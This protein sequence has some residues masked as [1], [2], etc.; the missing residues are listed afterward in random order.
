MFFKYRR[1]LVSVGILLALLIISAFYFNN[2]KPLPER[3]AQS[4]QSLLVT[5]E[6]ASEDDLPIKLR[7]YG[8]LITK[9]SVQL[10]AQAEG[11]IQTVNISDGE[12]VEAEQLLFELENTSQEARL[13]QARANLS[14]AELHFDRTKKL[15]DRGATSLQEFDQAKSSLDAQAAEV[16]L[17]QDEWDKTQIKAPFAG[18]LS[19]QEVSLGETVY[20]G[21]SLIRLVDNNN[22]IAQ[23]TVPEK[24]L[25][26]IKLG[27]DINITT[28][29]YKDKVYQAQVTYIAPM[30]NSS[31][32][33][34]RVEAKIIS[35]HSDLIAGMSIN[36]EHII[37]TAEK[38]ITVP[39]ESIHISL[40]GA[41]VFVV[42]NN[43]AYE[44][45]VKIGQRLNGRVEIISGLSAD[46]IVVTRGTQQVRNGSSVTSQFANIKSAVNNENI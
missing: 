12:Q 29:A 7:A 14:L 19:H 42:K 39:E 43:H 35:E 30:V 33:S 8:E 27:Q 40:E 45:P 16:D 13:N 3:K 38:T 31:S 17:Y 34:V 32:R 21:T 25:S 41:N 18:T 6:H 20:P 9:Q 10:S 1:M 24:Y 15:Y 28:P 44:T 46:S 37:G 4:E 5:V 22:L 36:I 26:S 2:P 23:F 11:R